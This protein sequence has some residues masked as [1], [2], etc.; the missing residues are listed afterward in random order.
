MGGRFV[1]V[2]VVLESIPVFWLGIVNIPSSVLAR[3]R[4][5]M[6]NFL[7]SGCGNSVRVHL[8][9]WEDLAKPKAYGGWGI[10]NLYWFS[11]ALAANTLWRCLMRDGLWHRVIK[12]KY[13]SSTSVVSW[14]RRPTVS[15]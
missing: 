9:K 10:K 6:F 13:L 4:Q 8:C 15:L 2:K 11:R 5:L 12:D 3:I 7:W 14:L 1:L